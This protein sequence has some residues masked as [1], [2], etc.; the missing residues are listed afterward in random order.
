VSALFVGL[1]C[2]LKR[3]LAYW[4]LPFCL[5]FTLLK[6][7]SV[8]MEEHTVRL[9]ENGSLFRIC[10][11]RRGGGDGNCIIGSS[12]FVLS[13][14][15]YDEEVREGDMGGACRTRGRFYRCI[16]LF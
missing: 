14:K 10:G 5:L 13:T 16:S 15:P 8:T 12:W 9:S 6:I 7:L 11:A 4:K 2:Y 3:N 1:I